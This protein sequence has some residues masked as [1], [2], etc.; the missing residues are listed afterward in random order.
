[1]AY[2]TQHK[3][4]EKQPA[5]IENPPLSRSSDMTFLAWKRACEKHKTDPQSLKHVF[6]SIVMTPKTQQVVASILQKMGKPIDDRA[7]VW[8]NQTPRW[9]QKLTFQPDSDEGKALLGTIQLKGVVWTLLQHRAHI[10]WKTIKSISV[11]RGEWSG[12]DRDSQTRVYGPSF[13]IELE[14]VQSRAGPSGSGPSGSGPSGS[15]KSGSR[16]SGLGQSGSKQSGSKQ[17]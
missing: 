9:E 10:G 5:G 1:M 2:S 4:K 12:S 15:G 8:G 14:D 7:D 6:I 16:K 3:I 13:Y 17:S 11:F